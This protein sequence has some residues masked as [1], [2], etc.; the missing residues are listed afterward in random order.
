M[1]FNKIINMTWEKDDVEILD[2][3]LIKTA[4][5]KLPEGFTYDPD[6]LYLKVKAVSAGEA[7]GSNKNDDYFPMSELVGGYKTFLSAHVFKNHDNKAIEKAIGDVLCSDWSEKMQSVYLIIRIDKR[8]A[9]S[10][11]RGYEKGFMTDVSM[12]CRVD[13]VVC[14]YCGQKAKTRFDYCEHLKNMKGKLMDNGKKIYEI[15]MGPKFH[16]IS[17]VLNG[18]ERSAKVENMLESEKVA[19]ENGESLEKCASVKM[20]DF[21][22]SNKSNFI[23]DS[24]IID[25]VAS[26]ML[27]KKPTDEVI[28]S[29]KEKIDNTIKAKALK[30]IAKDKIGGLEDIIDIIK[31]NYTKYWNK[32][33]CQEV[34]I[35]LRSIAEKNGISCE[36]VLDQF[37]KMSDF[38]AINLSPLEIHDIM[39]ETLDMD[40]EDLRKM[41][42]KDN[43]LVED[44]LRFTH[45]VP[46]ILKV[47]KIVGRENNENGINF[48]NLGNDN[49]ADIINSVANGLADK[50]FSPNS[51]VEDE[52]FED[53]L[54]SEMNERSCHRPF[55]IPRLREIAS[56]RINPVNSSI[57][58]SPLKIV[59]IQSSNPSGIS[60]SPILSAILNSSYQN[61]RVNRFN[62]GELEHGVRKIA[63]L[64]GMYDFEKT[65]G[66]GSKSLIVGLPAVGAYSALQRSR[67]NNGEQIS[68]MNRYVAENP[69]NA[70]LMYFI[71][72]HAAKKNGKNITKNIVPKME[73]YVSAIPSKVNNIR[74]MAFSQDFLD[75]D[76]IDGQ[77]EKNGLND[78]QIS[79]VKKASILYAVDKCDL[80]EDLLSQN[81]LSQ[82]DLEEYLK[83]AC[84]CIKMNIEK[85]ASFIQ[86]FIS[87]DFSGEINFQKMANENIS[88]P[89][90]FIDGIVL[91]EF[92]DELYKTVNNI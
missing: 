63:S 72:Q 77:L 80:G 84:D 8:I 5:L 40:S 64:C 13:H 68:S 38:A 17:C 3:D 75:N 51:F 44:D 52:I 12:G 82:S 66:I 71:I 26:V 62:S 55:F 34:G 56:G 31:L 54:S 53:I 57:H 76:K 65:A 21:F 24:S 4:A 85:N 15:N 32:A 42:L 90:Y 91:S 27:E 60:L 49:I 73:K 87:K 59:K 1:S 45:S 78:N 69:G 7:W 81:N 58:F 43:S 20:N 30:E 86:P 18:A 6:Y 14:P 92:S 22:T 36:Q 88:I 70:G 33:K 2:G 61:E 23:S 11:V 39:C 10:I 41:K 83:V 25:K 47:I 37:L 67:M 79:V 28:K 19:T 50:R 29:G 35:K 46:K 9:P 74:K 48:R 89:G 16:D